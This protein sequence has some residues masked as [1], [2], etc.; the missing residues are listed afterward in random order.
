MATRAPKATSAGE[1][2]NGHNA[3]DFLDGFEAFTGGYMRGGNEVPA[4]T[5]SSIELGLN[6]QAYS[7]IGR[8]EHV[9]LMFNR[10][11]N[12]IAIKPAE[13][14]QASAYQVRHPGKKRG[15]E[16]AAG[17]RDGVGTHF[18]T[19]RAFMAHYEIELPANRARY[20]VTQHGD[21]LFIDLNTEP[22]QV[23]TGQRSGKKD[24]EPLPGGRVTVEGDEQAN[25]GPPP[26]TDH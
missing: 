14:S 23:F 24:A 16:E 8:P 6:D 3:G 5:A 10:A 1:N 13:K 7:L 26:S 15:A 21:V 22:I 17:N 20:T 2:T 9:V 25:A 12:T 11:R 19:A 18:V 4:V